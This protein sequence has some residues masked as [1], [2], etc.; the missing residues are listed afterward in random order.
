MDGSRLKLLLV[1][2]G[3]NGWYITMPFRASV[4]EE[5]KS[6]PGLILLPSDGLIS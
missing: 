1:P 6:W 2:P 4:L 3:R 5:R